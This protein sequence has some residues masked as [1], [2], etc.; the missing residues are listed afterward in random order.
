[1]VIIIMPGNRV[2]GGSELNDERPIDIV[3]GDGDDDDDDV[4]D[5]NGVS[6][7]DTNNKEYSASMNGSEQDAN[8]I[9]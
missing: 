6:R 4:Y 2:V 8:Q 1:M 5:E 9:V 3:I 7:V